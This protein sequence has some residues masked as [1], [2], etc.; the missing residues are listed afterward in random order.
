MQKRGFTL[1]EVL[2]S[3]TLIAIIGSFSFPVYQA[4]Q[5]KN[6]TA[7]AL[8]VSRNALRIAQARSQFGEQDAAW[9]V[10]IGSG[11]V[12]IFK[13]ENYA[14][15]DTAYDETYSISASVLPQGTTEIFFAKITGTPSATGTITFINS[16]GDTQ[17]LHI[18]NKGVISY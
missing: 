8:N 4:L 13:G 1:I 11:D 18:H 16:S 12:T 14:A 5:V 17:Y 9:G 7:L 3:I 6:D 10:Y 2:L 15:R